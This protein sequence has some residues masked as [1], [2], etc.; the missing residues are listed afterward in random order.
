VLR[1]AGETIA[2]APVWI[3]EQSEIDRMIEGVRSI[4]KTLD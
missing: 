4:L 3:A 1:V 2:L